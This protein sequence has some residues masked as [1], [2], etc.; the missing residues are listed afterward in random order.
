MIDVEDV[1]LYRACLSE[2]AA[3]S[4]IAG[5]RFKGRFVQILLALKFFQEQIPSMFSNQFISTGVL[6][7]LLD[8][9][10]AKASRPPG[11]CVLMLFENNYLP[12]T[13]IRAAGKGPQNT[14]RN[15]LQLQKGVGCYAPSQDLASPTFLKQRRIDCKYLVPAVRGELS[16]AT[17]G[18]CPSGAQYRKEDHRKWL[19]IDRR[20]SGYAVTDLNNIENFLP[21]VVPKGVRIPILP[22]I[23]ALYHDSLP[24]LRIS[25]RDKVGI[26]DFATDF[27]FSPEELQKYFDGQRSNVHNR[28]LIQ[29]FRGCSHRGMNISRFGKREAQRRTSSQSRLRS[30]GVQPLYPSLTGTQVPPPAINTGWE[31][32]RCAAE[33]LTQDGWIVYDVSRQQLGYD[34]CANKGTETR[35]IDVKSSLNRCAPTLTVR[36]WEQ[37]EIHGARYVLA[38]LENFNPTGRNVIFWVPDPTGN[39][40]ARKSVSVQYSIARWSWDTVAVDLRDI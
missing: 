25:G 5:R 17:C 37:A 38:I 1:Q 15:N 13:G 24:G 4:R 30:R 40:T 26:E 28:R 27:S 23:G 34:L 33:A 32:E 7:T 19:R 11:A 22:L 2:L 36:E 21:Y 16:G 10:Y 29:G 35:Y 3:Y 9:L 14:W 31:A 6:Q 18:L 39:V 20:G 12:R 8:D